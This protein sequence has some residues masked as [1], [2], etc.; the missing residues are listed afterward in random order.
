MDQI[1]D[2]V[3]AD[4]TVIA[5]ATT[6]GTAIAIALVALWLAAAWWGYTDAARRTDSTL[7]ALLVASWIVVSTPFLLP[8]S[9]SIYALARPQHT[10]SEHRTRRL[11]AALV[12]QMEAD[13]AGRCL[14]CGATVDP[15]WNRCPTCTTWLALPCADCGTWS[16]RD[17]AVCPFC[18]GEERGEPAAERVAAVEA[19]EP[20]RAAPAAPRERRNRRRARAAGSGRQTVPRPAPRTMSP[21]PRPAPAAAAAA[22][23]ASLRGG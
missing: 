16:A 7:A 6:V 14:S 19:S 22:A 20:V 18:G 21:E 13:P 17:L 15:A 3:F 2:Q 4:P 23:A 5:V 9:L 11:A 10:A 12:D 8:L 1:F